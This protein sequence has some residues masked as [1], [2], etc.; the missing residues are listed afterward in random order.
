MNDSVK[1]ATGSIIVFSDANA[2]YE[3]D[4]IRELVGYFADEDIGC[5]TGRKTL[6][7]T[8]SIGEQETVTRSEKLYWRYE[9]ILKRWE[10]ECGSTVGVTGEILAVRRELFDP[11]EKGVINDDAYIALQI[12][13]RNY[14]VVFAPRAICYEEPSSSVHVDN[15]RRIRMSAGR[16]QLYLDFRLSKSGNP[17]DSF[18]YFFP[19][20]FASLSPLLHG[21]SNYCECGSNSIPLSANAH[22]GNL[23]GTVAVL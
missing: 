21:C 10:S 20:D 13:R 15:E 4:S 12:L 17:L 18:K 7:S 19:Q 22:D 8:D 14:R 11:I 5:V 23:D 16:W 6:R 9:N 1:I 3:S 2:F